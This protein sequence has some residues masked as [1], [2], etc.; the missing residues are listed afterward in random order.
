MYAHRTVTL[1]G[2]DGYGKRIPP[3]RL[4]PLFQQIGPAIQKSV[5]M[6][7][8]GSS[9][10]RGRRPNWLAAASDLRFVD[11]SGNGNTILHFEAPVFGDA[12]PELYAQGELWPM[13]PDPAATGF[14]LLAEVVCDIGARNQDSEVFDR[15]LLVQIGH[16]DKVFDDHVQCLRFGDLSVRTTREPALTHAVAE[17]AREL[18]AA[19]PPARR[20]RVVG[21]L[22]MLWQSRQA[23]SLRLAENPDEV[24]GSLL[25]GDITELKDLLG[26]RVLVEG[27]AVYRPSRR[28]LRI[29]AERVM[30]AGD[31]YG[32]WDSV[33]P[34]LDTHAEP[35]GWRERQTP[36]TGVNAIIGKWPGDETDEE[37][38]E[39]LEHLS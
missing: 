39:A 14:D 38:F 35:S 28:V 36:Q 17:A 9:A 3:D 19:T 15:P 30:A 33:P 25:E 11:Y 7:F 23:F 12:A 31:I 21:V 27:K 26:Q 5:R 16:F 4:G 10:S 6:R 24:R 13:R 8:L 20:V 2:P 22:D 34:T 32:P 1:S 37:V 18:R 29:D